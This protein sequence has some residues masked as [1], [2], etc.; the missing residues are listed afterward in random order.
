[1][2]RSRREQAS[3]PPPRIGVGNHVQRGQFRGQCIL[4]AGTSELVRDP[5]QREADPGPEHGRV[6]GLAVLSDHG[7]V[8]NLPASALRERTEIVIVDVGDEHHV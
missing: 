5:G 2:T 1:V 8:A 3:L 7:D 4:V 6:E